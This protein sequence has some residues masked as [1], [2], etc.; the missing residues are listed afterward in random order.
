[1]VSSNSPVAR[2]NYIEEAITARNHD[3][4]PRTA[5]DGEICEYGN[6]IGIPVMVVLRRELKMPFELSGVGIQRDD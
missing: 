5:A 3:D 6:L 1:L 2:S 4:F